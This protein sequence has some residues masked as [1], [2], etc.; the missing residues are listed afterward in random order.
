MTTQQADPSKIDV[1]IEQVGH[2]TEGLT[3]IKM[4]VQEQSETSRRQAET[5]DRLV[6]IVEIL[7][8]NQQ[9]K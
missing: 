6:R 4:M 5:T 3:E 1:L 7:L 2:L 9:G 8:Q